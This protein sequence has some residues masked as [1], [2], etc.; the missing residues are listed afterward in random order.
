MCLSLS[1]KSLHE[2]WRSIDMERAVG[3]PTRPPSLSLP[4]PEPSAASF[5]ICATLP[6]R[7]IP[8]PGRAPLRSRPIYHLTLQRTAPIHQD[9]GPPR[10]FLIIP[11]AARVFHNRPGRP[12]AEHERGERRAA[13]RKETLAIE[14]ESHER[15]F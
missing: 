9:A 1:I 13:D 14:S 7:R 12:W 11:F 15:L 3:K 4:N 10:R 2:T 6:P 8:P 5:G